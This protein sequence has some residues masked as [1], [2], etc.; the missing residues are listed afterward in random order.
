MKL[1]PGRATTCTVP[2]AGFQAMAARIDLS[3]FK[4]EAKKKKNPKTTTPRARCSL[5]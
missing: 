5:L 2:T 4:S 1:Q 3:L